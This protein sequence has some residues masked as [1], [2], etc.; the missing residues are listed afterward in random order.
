MSSSCNSAARGGD[1]DICS[2][3]GRLHNVVDFISEPNI[4]DMLFQENKI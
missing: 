4:R 2:V 1:R 3:S